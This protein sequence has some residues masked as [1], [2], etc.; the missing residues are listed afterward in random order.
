MKQYERKSWGY[1]PFIPVETALY[2]GMHKGFD[3]HIV[4]LSVGN[5]SI[6]LEWLP[7]EKAH[8]YRVTVARRGESVGF[9][10]NAPKGL[11]EPQ[12]LPAGQTHCQFNGLF[13]GVDY[14]VTVFALNQ[15][16]KQIARSFNRLFRA[17]KFAGTVINY[18]HPD[19]YSYGF[20]G[21][22]IENPSVLKLPTGAFLVSSQISWDQGESNLTI[23]FRSDDKGKSWK[24]V[25]D[26][27]PCSSGKLF[28]HND[29]IYL[30]GLDRKKGN[31][32]LGY[33]KDYGQTW[34]QPVIIMNGSNNR[35]AG[36]CQIPSPVII[37]EGRIWTALEW[38]DEEKESS[39]AGILSAPVDSD[40]LNPDNWRLS[41]F[42]SEK[43]YLTQGCA[44]V[45]KDGSIG[46]LLQEKKQNG[47]D[48]VLLTLNPKQPEETQKFYGTIDVPAGNSQMYVISDDIKGGYLGVSE[49]LNEA[50]SWSSG[51]INLMS[52]A[53][54]IQWKKDCE[55]IDCYVND[56]GEI[57]WK[58]GLN[59][60]SA[61]GEKKNIY[62]AT[63]VAMN[64]A[65]N[66]RTANAIVFNHFVRE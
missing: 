1:K 5:E 20:S 37:H 28:L 52:S 60:S 63:T 31:C 27:C 47:V 11:P 6:D 8:Q 61:V 54:G 66:G 42:I 62:I 50:H 64:G 13:N 40:L 21:R 41:P 53:D 43:K 29:A 25:S 51:K 15:D 19:D 44:V 12:F 23:I 39:A 55:L 10:N 24:Y 49:T 30:L 46:N 33:S 7:Y 48:T 14:E 58:T 32:L 56:N 18:I 17:G 57:S 16:G 38:V 36:I 34:S 4:R 3:V 22:S 59:Q 65:W 9:A 35:K 26:I 2:G 45:L